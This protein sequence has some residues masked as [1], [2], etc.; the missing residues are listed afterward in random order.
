MRVTVRLFARLRELAG[1]GELMRE[2]PA[3]ATVAT[4][5]A[6]LVDEWPELAPYRAVDLVR[7]ECRLLTVHRAGCGGRRGGIPAAGVRR[8]KG[9]LRVGA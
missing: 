4:I 6:G 9:G 3:N 2:V 1:S 7:G 8:V 5:W